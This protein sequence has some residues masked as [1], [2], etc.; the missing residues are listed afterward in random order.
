MAIK[1]IVIK[2]LAVKAGESSKDGWASGFML[3]QMG[4][5]GFVLIAL[6]SQT[7]VLPLDVASMLL[8]AGVI[9]MAITPYMINNARTWALFISQEKSSESLSLSELSENKT[10]EDHVIICGFGRIG[11]TVSRFFKAR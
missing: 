10:L 9:S 8:G 11:Q 4:E 5:F 6:A 7:N 1:V 3:A 2:M